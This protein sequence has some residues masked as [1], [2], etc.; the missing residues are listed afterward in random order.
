MYRDIDLYKELHKTNKNYGN[1]GKY[2]CSFINEYLVH[3]PNIKNVLDFGCG[4]STL[5]QCL[6]FHIDEYDPAISGKEQISKSKYDL[7]ITTDVLEHLYEDEIPLICQ[8]FLSLQP[9]KMLHFI[10]TIK[11]KQILPDGSNAHKTI[12][13][14]EWWKTHIHNFT[15]YNINMKEYATFVIL[16][17]T[18]NEH[19]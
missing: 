1:T 18:S 12:Q 17:C 3:Y 7:I 5:S 13:N 6:D 11:A 2:Y 4:K 19:F 8:E 10:C 15:K 14:G 16:E 9:Y